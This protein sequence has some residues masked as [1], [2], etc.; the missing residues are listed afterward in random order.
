M[1]QVKV[2][3][4]EGTY[5]ELRLPS[6]AANPYLV[7]AA[8]LVAG[9]D[10]INNALELPAPGSVGAAKLPGSLNE[11]LIALEADTVMVCPVFISSR[12]D[13]K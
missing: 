9:L 4:I 2:D 6:S 3:G 1:L 7:Q 10:G 5:I 12:N 13:A 11:A 8:M